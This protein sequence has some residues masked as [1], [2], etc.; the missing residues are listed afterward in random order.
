MKSSINTVQNDIDRLQVQDNRLGGE[1]ERLQAEENNYREALKLLKSDLPT[2]EFL[3][4]LENAQPEGVWLET[5]QIKPGTVFLK[6]KA[7]EEN[8]VVIFAKA[9]LDNRLVYDVGF[10]ETSR[11]RPGPDGMSIVDFSFS[12]QI[13]SITDIPS[14]FS[15]GGY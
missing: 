15:G 7:W 9:L 13:V 10:P 2:L 3:A 12:C 5:I 6:G 8:D 4:L 11:G 1:L 14:R